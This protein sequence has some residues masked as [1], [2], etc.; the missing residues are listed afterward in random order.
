LALLVGLA[1]L[2][3]LTSA[4][5]LPAPLPL[6][7][8]TGGQAPLTDLEKPGVIYNSSFELTPEGLDK[9]LAGFQDDLLE[10]VKKLDWEEAGRV[11]GR[12]FWE[13]FG[14]L[15]MYPDG[16]SKNYVYRAGST[17]VPGTSYNDKAYAA[18][19][20]IDAAPA[21]AA[22]GIA[23]SAAPASAAPASFSAAAAVPQEEEAP[24]EAASF[25]DQI[26]GV[27][28]N[29]GDTFFDLYDRTQN[30]L[31]ENGYR[32]KQP[33]PDPSWANVDTLQNL[34]IYT[35]AF[36]WRTSPIDVADQL[37]DYVQAVKQHANVDKVYLQSVSASGSIALAYID[38]YINK[39]GCDDI[40]GVFISISL[41]NGMGTLGSVYEKKL[42]PDARSLSYA[43]KMPF[44][45]DLSYEAQ[46]ILKTLH[47]MG[48]LDV[49]CSLLEFAPPALLDSFYDSA[50]VPLY[51]TFLG[52]WAL[53][54]PDM[55]DNAKLACFG[56]QAQIAAKG[57]TDFVAKAD[58]YHALQ[59]NCKEILRA[60]EAKD[61]LKLAVVAGY[62][63]SPWPISSNQGRQA[64]DGV[65]T[66][67]ASFGATVSK[68]GENLGKS[69]TQA[70]KSCEHNHISPDNEIDASTAALP[71][72][73]WF[74]KGAIH[75]DQYDWN[76]L[77]AWWYSTDNPT[78][79]RSARWPQYLYAYGW[80]V[81]SRQEA[82]YP[83]QTPVYEGSETI[84]RLL[85]FWNSILSI[86]NRI[87]FTVVGGTAKL[88][89]GIGDLFQ[90]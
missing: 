66:V 6:I 37:Y 46:A 45:G 28:S 63:L 67:Y 1:G 50:F 81:M 49:L 69:Y 82:V 43:A 60:A 11:L 12:L 36:D 25:M 34:R 73:T 64:D 78:V 8:I 13:S 59:V 84:A 55:Y 65:E 70:D 41:A 18:P 79:T 23:A 74:V 44:V 62:G 9:L 3:F 61:G 7:R 17:A 47:F 31:D 29:L 10:A 58:A 15:Q 87:V 48:L 54:P 57:Y 26:L 14:D 2:P 72:N 51:G 19:K 27:L 83:L 88:I 40:A 71:E 56:N 30:Y 5:A 32:A 77:F 38:K 76:G 75:G 52:M 4:A 86:W 85:V 16:T 90:F 21:P 80:R 89:F 39:L 20:R 35:F 53:V 24:P 68:L 22:V 42:L 33:E